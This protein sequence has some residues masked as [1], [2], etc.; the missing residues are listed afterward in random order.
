MKNLKIVVFVKPVPDHDAIVEVID[1]ELKVEQRWLVNF[2]DEIAV[3]QA[4]RIKEATGAEVVA[5]S[6]KTDSA[7]GKNVS[8]LRR[9]LAIGVNRIVMIE[10]EAVREADATVVSRV[11][12]RFV[13]KECASI[14]LC[15]RLALDD[16]FGFVPQ[17]VA[18]QL[19]W[20]FVCGV[21]GFEM[22][23]DGAKLKR[24]VEGGEEIVEVKFPFVAGVVKG[25][26]EPRVPKVK[27]IMSSARAKPEVTDCKAIGLRPDELKK[28]VYVE[29]YFNP[30]SRPPAK[31]IKWEGVKTTDRVVE[32]IRLITGGR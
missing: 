30:P 2:F 14:V 17:A 31:M 25:L 3:E 24:L 22:G 28:M 1:G 26:C 9:A 27:N 11:L 15:G 32:I 8:A 4:V 23:E 5:V 19:G 12:A 7:P 13:K 18:M 29:S 21:V 10:D 20:G 6:V 16:E